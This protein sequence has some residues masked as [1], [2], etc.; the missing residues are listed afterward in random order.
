MRYHTVVKMHTVNRMQTFGW[1][2]LIMLMALAVVLA[3][4][5]ALH[6]VAD[7]ESIA[8]MNTGMMF[9]G[10]IFTALGPIVA[11]GFISMGQFFPL[12][13][14]L[15]ITRREYVTGTALV[16]LGYAVAFTAI[17]VIGKSI[18][19]ATGGYGL[20]VRFFDVVYVGTGPLWQT[21]IQTF[22]IAM[23]AM[24][25]GSAF[26]AG[27]FRW[28]QTFVWTF[29]VIVAV[30]GAAIGI[31]AV[32]S[33]AV[34]NWFFSLFSLDWCAYMA[35]MVAVAAIAAVAWSLLVRRTQLR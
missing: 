15:G 16:F 14:G 11:L 7:A 25:V 33:P 35:L 5:V 28:R 34:A 30:V 4:G 27:Y 23:M 12:A 21:A 19:L 6:Q 8:D 9:N 26:V 22:L 17:V 31:M 2:L 1:P 20:S 29:F 3:I 32:L 18:E 10:A 13:L 24:L